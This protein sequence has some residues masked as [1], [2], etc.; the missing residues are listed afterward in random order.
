MDAGERFPPRLIVSNVVGYFFRRGCMLKTPILHPQILA[1]LGRAGH[2]SKILIADGNYPHYT[3]RGP[4]AEVVF[5]NF[6]PGLLS[7]TDVLTG[8]ANVVPIELAEVMEPNRSGPYAMKDDPP[9]FEDFRKILKA[10]NAGLELTRLERF[11]FYE[12]AGTKDVT[13][14]IATG[15]ERIYANILLTIGVVK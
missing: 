9:I 15:E 10:Q 6:T 5:L 13:L 3:K 2:S 8:I 12:A 1:A 4:N 14:T 7:V 11:A